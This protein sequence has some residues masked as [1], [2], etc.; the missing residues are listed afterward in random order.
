MPE[1]TTPQE[2]GYLTAHL[3]GNKIV[4]WLACFVT[5]D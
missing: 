3:Y 5:H 2:V 1:I 4:F